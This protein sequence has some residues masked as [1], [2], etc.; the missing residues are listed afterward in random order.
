[1]ICPTTFAK[2]SPGFAVI[3][4]GQVT[5]VLIIISC[6]VLEILLRYVY[7]TRQRGLDTLGTLNFSIILKL[8]T[9]SRPVKKLTKM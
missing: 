8:K 6:I 4:L 2:V 9:F 5:N 3:D 1:M 7:L